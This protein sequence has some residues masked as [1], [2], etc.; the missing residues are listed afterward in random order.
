MNSSI[1]LSKKDESLRRLVIVKALLCIIGRKIAATPTTDI[2]TRQRIL[3]KILT[4]SHYVRMIEGHFWVDDIQFDC[5]KKILKLLN[6][7]NE[8]IKYVYD[9]LLMYLRQ[10]KNELK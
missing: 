7:N 2:V 6:N 8:Y 5:L 3:D 9:L 1:V 10:V 4:Y